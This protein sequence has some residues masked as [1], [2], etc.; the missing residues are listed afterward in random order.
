MGAS[1]MK[2]KIGTTILFLLV[3]HGVSGQEPNVVPLYFDNTLPAPVDGGF[4]MDGYWVWGS[5]VIQDE[6]GLYHMF[7]SRWPK[8]LPF[9]PGWM[10][11]SE[12]VHAVSK[13]PE[14]P[15]QFSDVT[16]P[17]R[18]AQFWDGHSTHNPRI[19]RY[20]DTYVL[21]YMGST[22]PFDEITNPSQ[23][24][25]DSYYTTVARSNKR[26]GI[27]TSKSPYGPWERRDA[28]LLATKPN[29]FYSFLT[30]N[31]APW[32]NEDGSVLLI[33]KSRAY[34]ESFPY[35]G[36]MSICVATAPSI[37]GPYTVFDS[38]IFSR[39]KFGEVEDPFV[40]K[41]HDGYHLL[42]KDQRGVITGRKHSGVIAHSRDGLHWVLDKNPLAYTKT[43][44][45]S[46]GTIQEMGQLERA[47]GLIQNG[48]IT[49]LFFATM[50]GPGGFNNATKSWNMVV[51]LIHSA[52]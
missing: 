8:R 17:E 33:F 49:H 13:T 42:V 4:R 52:K 44:T 18:G 25:L 15:Y 30:S 48:K 26:I 16:L 46:D 14:G 28:P 23:L 1:Q 45:W 10:V 9:H 50:D 5:S 11:A 27:A 35:H 47:F 22:H 38:P 39:E 41:D 20:K 43:I 32:I 37:D 3:M 19:T 12:V 51:P 21:F 2:Y 29:T 40:W 7:A 31:P 24:T 34:K 6:D 36:D